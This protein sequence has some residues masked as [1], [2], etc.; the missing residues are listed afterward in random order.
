MS[1]SMRALTVAVVVVLA[2]ALQSAPAAGQETVD[3]QLKLARGEVLYQSFT[4]S[5]ELTLE[6]PSGRSTSTLEAEARGVLRVLDV[7]ASGAMLI[8]DVLEDLRVTAAGR[9]EPGIVG[10]VT[11]RV[12][13]DGRVV[14]RQTGDY[15]DEDYPL[16]LP[17][18]PVR[19]GETWT[20]Q[21]RFEESGITAQAT[22]TY[23][24]AALEGTGDARQARIIYRVDGRVTGVE[25]GQLPA[26]VQA[27]SSGTI[28]GG[29]EIAWSV[30]RGRSV[31]ARDELTIDVVIEATDRGQA[32]RLSMKLRIANRNEP[33][34]AG[35]VTVP[36]VAADLLIAPGKGIG[37]IALEMRADDITSR[38][39]PPTP[40]TVDAGLRAPAVSWPGG[41]VGYLD[42]DDRARVVGLEISDRQH[43]TEK[44]I[45]FGSSQ[46]AVLMAYG[47]SP[48]RVE[49][50][51][52]NLGGARVLIYNDLG[53]A[54]AVTSDKQHAGAG[55]GH[56]PVGAVD[57][58]TVFPAGGAR[59]I[60][61]LP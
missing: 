31:R 35:S 38:Q 25:L 4:S 24:L 30:P 61:T 11:L 9:T 28:Q 15:I 45:G 7:D 37:V 39:G 43:R 10:P 3:L 33:L 41:L 53:I 26:G 52:P 12:R 44:G 48:A 50:T 23:T 17:G 5:V 21:T 57:W 36:A 1:R 8:E 49:L 20:R 34:P 22:V 6:T 14:E 27:Q 40:R 59:R 58:I 47:M 51:I 54:F 55:P 29:G 32:V 16:A 60:F 13:P 46:G 56:A 42:P 19:V 2:A 18:R